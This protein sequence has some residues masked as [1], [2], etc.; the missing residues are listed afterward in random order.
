[1]SPGLEKDKINGQTSSWQR[2]NMC[3][4]FYIVDSNKNPTEIQIYHKYP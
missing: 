3:L 1:M 4:Q 2:L